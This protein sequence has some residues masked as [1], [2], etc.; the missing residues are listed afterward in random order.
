MQTIGHVRK[1][2][3]GAVAMDEAHSGQPPLL[4]TF[5]SSARGDASR[6]PRTTDRA[7]QFG[8][9]EEELSALSPQ[10]LIP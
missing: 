9:A 2:R 10:S 7:L 5:G 6:V 4:V 8:F 3:F 1:G